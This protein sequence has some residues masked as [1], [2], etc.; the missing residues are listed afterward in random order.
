MLLHILL[1]EIRL[2]RL[3][4][5][6]EADVRD[7]IAAQQ[8]LYKLRLDYLRQSEYMNEF[9]TWFAVASRGKAPTR[10]LAAHVWSEKACKAASA[11]LRMALVTSAWQRYGVLVVF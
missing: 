11:D 3:V 1:T 10:I 2:G 8:A 4:R 9:G 6:S 7:R 5:L